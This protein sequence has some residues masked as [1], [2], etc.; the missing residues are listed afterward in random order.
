MTNEQALEL[1]A[2]TQALLSFLEEDNL[3]DYGA[4][5][6]SAII[7]TRAAAAVAAGRPAPQYR[8]TWGAGFVNP[9]ATV[10][11]A[12]FF[13]IDRG[14]EQEDLAAIARLEVGAQWTAA[15]AEEH[16]VERI[17]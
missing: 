3:E 16:T 1:L 11:A 2:A 14:Y 13:T 15:T 7:R 4:D 12:A 17:A 8:A 9:R 5:R 10:V 6:I